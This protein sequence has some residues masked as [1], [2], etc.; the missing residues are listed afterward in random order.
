MTGVE[1]RATRLSKGMTQTDMGNLLQ[2]CRQTIHNY[3]TEKRKI[4]GA[5]EIL[6]CLLKAGIV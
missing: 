2:V 5:V 4:P 1:F 6:I 3:E